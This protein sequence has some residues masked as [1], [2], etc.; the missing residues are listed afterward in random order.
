MSTIF[1]NKQKLGIKKE[2]K[3][4]NMK[5]YRDSQVTILKQA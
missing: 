2:K 5:T 4:N 1:S 3:L